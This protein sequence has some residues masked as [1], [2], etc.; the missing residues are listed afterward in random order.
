MILGI[1]KIFRNFMR[2]LATLKIKF[3]NAKMTGRII[4]PNSKICFTALTSQVNSMSLKMNSSKTFAQSKSSW[5]I[6]T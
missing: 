2:V 4:R 3:Q 1:S 5:N 6:Q